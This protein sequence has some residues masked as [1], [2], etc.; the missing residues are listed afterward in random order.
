M[1]IDLK[2]W[3][4][5]DDKFWENEGKSIANR[6]LWISI[7][8]LLCGF[9]I[10]LMWGIITVQM[11][12]LGFTFGKS[13]EE[14][15]GLLFML[16]AIAGLTGA[17]LRIPSTFFIRLAGGRNTIFFTTALLMIPCIG[18]AI[19]LQDPSTSFDFFM[20]PKISDF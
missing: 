2:E 1:S 12:S 7:P 15:M 11:K 5:E 20:V 9:A 16:P 10:W 13:P 14:A 18:T 6:N 17:T 3:N 4:V 8:S 19:G